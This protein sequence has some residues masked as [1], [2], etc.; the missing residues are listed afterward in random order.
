[1]E[2]DYYQVLGVDLSADLATIKQAYRK[3]A[4][5][6]HPDRGGSH[7]QMVLVNEAWEILSDPEL[8][9]RYDQARQH[10]EDH[11]AEEAA[12]EDSCNARQRAEEYPKQWKDF[13]AWLDVLS[14]DFARAEYGSRNWG[15]ITVP[16]AGYS[17]SGWIFIVA[18]AVLGAALAIGLFTLVTGQSKGGGP[19]L[20]I[21]F[22]VGAWAGVA[23]HKRLR[24]K[25][26]LR[27][28]D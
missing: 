20:L 14:Q 19:L 18:G 24:S 23:A 7:R 2:H 17:I 13:A 9:R 5:E 16:T 25:S 1:M 12:R 6:C 15:K 28:D 26:Q 8:R 21:S 27:G 11:D 3:K 4:I 22:V 10:S